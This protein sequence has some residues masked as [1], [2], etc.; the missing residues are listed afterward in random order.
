MV[1][2]KQQFEYTCFNYELGTC[3]K[4][5]WWIGTFGGD[6]NYL[7]NFHG[8]MRIRH[9]VNTVNIESVKRRL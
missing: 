7:S 1:K 4:W 3:C 5:D 2:E 6:L 9:N 8:R